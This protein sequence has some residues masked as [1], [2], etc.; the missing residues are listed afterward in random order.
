VPVFAGL[1]SP[2]AGYAQ[3]ARHRAE[4]GGKPA[5]TSRP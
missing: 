4:A 1:L 2:T 5:T 3:Q